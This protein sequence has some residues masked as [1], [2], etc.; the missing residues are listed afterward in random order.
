MHL[1][2]KRNSLQISTRVKSSAKYL[3]GSKPASVLVVAI[4][5]ALAYEGE[6]G[7]VT[8]IGPDGIDVRSETNF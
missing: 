8:A 6:A 5:Q 4:L 1:R 2:R 3:S 7:Q